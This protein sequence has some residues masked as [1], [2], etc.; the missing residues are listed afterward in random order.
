MLY[1]Q[2]KYNENKNWER[3]V[4]HLTIKRRRVMPKT[5]LAGSIFPDLEQEQQS[6]SHPKRTRSNDSEN[7]RKIEK[8]KESEG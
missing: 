3:Y 7:S 4:Y 2:L 5:S 6:L 8:I 1:T